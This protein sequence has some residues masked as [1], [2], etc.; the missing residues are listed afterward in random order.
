MSDHDY[1]ILLAA[2]GWIEHHAGKDAPDY[3]ALDILTHVVNNISERRVPSEGPNP[4][5]FGD[6]RATELR[7]QHRFD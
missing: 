7:R 3:P 1:A 5:S 4:P 6:E 2:V